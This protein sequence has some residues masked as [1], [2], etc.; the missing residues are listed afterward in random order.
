MTLMIEDNGE[1]LSTVCE[2]CSGKLL[3]VRR[4][5][6]SNAFTAEDLL[7]CEDIEA[8]EFQFPDVVLWV[9]CIGETDEI[10]LSFAAPSWTNPDIVDLSNDSPWNNV[11]GLELRFVWLLENDHGY[12]DG[13]Q[14][15]FIL[16]PENERIYRV[17]LESAASQI[18]VYVVEPA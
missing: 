13:V 12:R 10:R 15:E 9:I 3:R 7:S 5:R 4:V 1:K 11:V 6:T 17:E 2:R 16:P 18:L 8:L 14:F